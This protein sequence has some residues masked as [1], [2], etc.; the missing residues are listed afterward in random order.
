MKKKKFLI[1]GSTGFIGSHLTRRIAKDGYEVISFSRSDKPPIEGIMHMQGDLRDEKSIARLLRTRSD[2]VVSLVGL[3]GQTQTN[4]NHKKSFQINTLAHIK[5]LDGIIK[6][7][8]NTKMIF[9]SSRLEYGKPRYLPVDE[10]HPI[11]PI[12]F[13]GIHKHLVT[14]YCQFLNHKYGLPTVVLRASNPYGPYKRKQIV[15]YNVINHFI[16]QAMRDDTLS[17]FG[18]GAQKRDYIFIDDCI[19]A[20][21]AVALNSISNGEIYNIGGGVGISLYDAACT[22]IK[23]VGKG[24]IKKLPWPQEER[25]VETGDY[26][27][28]IGRIYRQTKWK[29]KYSFEQGIAKTIEQLSL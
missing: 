9:S 17:I 4:I 22:I 28:D 21:M 23:T 6:I 5:F 19:D 7:G 14:A 15:S 26:I 27:S 10:K 3:S 25:A 2:I 11:Q 1:I 8:S 24:I 12:S 18:G 29:P 16:H 13:Y 20:I